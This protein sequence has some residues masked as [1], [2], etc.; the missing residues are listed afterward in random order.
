VQEEVERLRITHLLWIST[1]SAGGE[2]TLRDRMF[3]LKDRIGFMGGAAVGYVLAGTDGRI[4]SANTLTQFGII[5]G[6]VQEFSEG[7][8]FEDIDY[9]PNNPRS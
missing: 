1:Y 6:V 9:K 4:L 3:F 5:G 2:S 8:K 7:Y